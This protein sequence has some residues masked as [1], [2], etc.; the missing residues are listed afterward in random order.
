MNTYACRDAVRPTA[1]PGPCTGIHKQMRQGRP[2]QAGQA[3]QRQRLGATSCRRRKE[4]KQNQGD[5]LPRNVVAM[6]RPHMPSLDLAQAA[7]Q[8]TG[9]S[10]GHKGPVPT[11]AAAPDAEG[12]C[13]AVQAFLEGRQHVI[14]L[15]CLAAELLEHLLGPG[16]QALLSQTAIVQL[17]ELQQALPGVSP[18]AWCLGMAVSGDCLG[19]TTTGEVLPL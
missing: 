1:A 11:K 8:S 3:Q 10:Q 5:G 16:Q 15:P 2:R 9:P 12:E 19:S 14:G 13:Q 17:L 7:L 4:N 18:A 6:F